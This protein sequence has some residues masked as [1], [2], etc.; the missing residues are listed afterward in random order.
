MH[1]AF[2]SSGFHPARKGDRTAVALSSRV[3]RPPVV[4]V[5]TTTVLS[6]NAKKCHLFDGSVDDERH[7]D[8]HEQDSCALV[9]RSDAG[10]ASSGDTRFRFRRGSLRSWSN[11][12]CGPRRGAVGGRVRPERGRVQCHTIT[13]S[14]SAKHCSDN[15]PSDLMP[16]H[17][18]RQVSTPA[19]TSRL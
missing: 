2:R 1:C 3:H 15:R 9:L 7:P 6:V 16:L 11:R 17:C 18:V 4:D 13:R 14:R 8:R 10:A 12:Q 5:G 19:T